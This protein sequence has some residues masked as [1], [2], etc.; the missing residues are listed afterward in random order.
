[1][2]AMLLCLTA[3]PVVASGSAP[4]PA[5][6]RAPIDDRQSEPES[7]LDCSGWC[8]EMSLLGFC[9]FRDWITRDCPQTCEAYCGEGGVA[10]V[11]LECGICECT[12]N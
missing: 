6:P 10:S 3:L 7:G 4:E 5:A 11:T 1:M 8:I 2:I 9:H 12:C